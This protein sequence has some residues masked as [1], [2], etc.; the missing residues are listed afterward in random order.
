[1]KV[2]SENPVTVTLSAHVEF[3]ISSLKTGLQHTD[4]HNSELYR[5]ISFIVDQLK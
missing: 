3:A 4:D 2:W 1:M 5:K